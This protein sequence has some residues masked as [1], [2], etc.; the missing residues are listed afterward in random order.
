MKEYNL[1]DDILHDFNY[2][3]FW[4][5]QNYGGSN[6]NQWLPGVCFCGEGDKLE[7]TQGICCS[8]AKW[9]H[10]LEPARLPCSWELL[11]HGM[12]LPFPLPGD[13]PD[14]GI[15][16]A[17]PALWADS[18]PLKHQ[19]SPGDFRAGK[20]A[21]GHSNDGHMPL[22]LHP[23]TQNVPSQEWTLK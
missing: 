20:N 10:G 19:G 13:L 14:P 3:T 23:N 17:P 6:N 5:R 11:L 12:S 18:L 22:H 7:G 4:K 1:K 15:E 2:M 21:A 9:P 8:V 16:P